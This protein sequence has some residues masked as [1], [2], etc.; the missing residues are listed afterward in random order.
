VKTR[1]ILGFINE[2]SQSDFR[3]SRFAV[4][5]T[6]ALGPEISA[7]QLEHWEATLTRFLKGFPIR[8]RLGTG[9]AKQP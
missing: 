1:Q 9:D 5:M 2:L 3:G 6:W 7:D 4:E 8:K